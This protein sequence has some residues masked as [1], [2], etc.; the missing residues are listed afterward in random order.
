VYYSDL[1]IDTSVIVKLPY[2]FSFGPWGHNNIG[3][4]INFC[5]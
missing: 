5:I 1:I 4:L 3:C 2:F